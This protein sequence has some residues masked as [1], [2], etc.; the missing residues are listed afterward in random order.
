[1]TARA[2]PPEPIAKRIAQI[3]DRIGRLDPYVCAGTLLSRTK[4]CGKPNCR[5]RRDPAARHGPY[6]EWTRM[7]NG[8]FAHK[9]LS[10]GQ[11][12]LLARAIKNYRVLQRLLA[13]WERESAQTILHDNRKKRSDR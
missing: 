11:A 13:R 7:E 5:C 8:R 12:R 4:V 1:M 10:P 3:R 9:I 2:E 6:F